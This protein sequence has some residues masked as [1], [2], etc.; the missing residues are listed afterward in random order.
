MAIRQ[1]ARGGPLGISQERRRRQ[2]TLRRTLPDRPHVFDPESRTT[3]LL[4]RPRATVRDAYHLLLQAPWWVNLLVIAGVFL[5]VNL[6][7]AGLYLAVGGVARARP[8]SFADAFFFSVQTLAT[9]G[10][11]E[12]HPVSVAANLTAL[13][14]GL[15]FAKF[16]VV[17]PRVVFARVAV[18]IADASVQLT[19][20]RTERTAEG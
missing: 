15:V 19:L 10:Y 5:A 2:G 14:T 12:M 3:E 8:G 11:G 1:Q 16:S 18:D 6:V 13:A 17:R 7:F 4:G 20:M 9:I